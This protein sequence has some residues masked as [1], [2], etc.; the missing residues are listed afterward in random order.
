[1]QAFGAPS[2]AHLIC[3]RLNASETNYFWIPK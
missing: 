1:M 3:E 2:M